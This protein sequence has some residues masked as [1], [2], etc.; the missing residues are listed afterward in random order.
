M[1]ILLIEDEPELLRLI[2]TYLSEQGHIVE[3][4][5]TAFE[6]ED[7]LLSYSYD[8]SLLDITLPDGNGLTLLEKFRDKLATMSVLVISAKDSLDDKIS[9]LNLGADDYIT[10]PFHLTELNARINAVI[11]RKNFGGSSEI[12]FNEITV[13]SENK[14]VYI[15]EVKLPLTRREYDILLYFI[16]NKNRLLT[17]ENIAEHVWEDN[18]DLADNYKFVYTH[19]ANLRKKMKD[20]GGEDYF[21]AV[22]GMG[23]KFTDL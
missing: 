4:A 14:E 6:A 2:D 21:K 19:V 15:R 17:K 8:I 11:R 16:T 3:K 20:A 10:K 7:K 1:K 12:V 22:Y 13:N 18:I 5:A 9:G 23:Y